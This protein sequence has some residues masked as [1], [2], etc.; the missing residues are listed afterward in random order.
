M[1]KYDITIITP[2]SNRTSVIEAKGYIREG[3]RVSFVDD[4]YKTIHSY[5][6]H[7]LIFSLINEDNFHTSDS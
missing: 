2:T 6:S 1:N 7:C 4:S 3:D 5:P